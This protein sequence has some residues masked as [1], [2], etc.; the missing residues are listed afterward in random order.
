MSP[1]KR[2]AIFTGLQS[3][4]RYPFS[5]SRRKR[6]RES[7]QVAHKIIIGSRTKSE[8]SRTILLCAHSIGE[9]IFGAERSLLDVAKALTDAGFNIVLAL[10]NGSNVEYLKQLQK[11]AIEI[12]IFPFDQ[13]KASNSKSD[14]SVAAIEAFVSVIDRVKP[15]LIYVNTIVLR[16]PLLA[17]KFRNVPTIVHVREIID[18][19]QDLQK[20][21]GLDADSIIEQLKAS[22]DCLIANSATTAESFVGCNNV[23]VIPNIVDPK[24]FDFPNEIAEGVV[25]FGLIS[26]NLLK[27]GIEDFIELARLCENSI[28]NARFSIIGPQHWDWIQNYISKRK[29]YPSNL[30]FIDYQDS[31]AR[32]IQLVNVVVNFS[33]FKESF[34][35]TVL[36]GMAAGRPTL[37]YDWGALNELVEDE[38]TG[39]LVPYREPNLAVKFV[40]VLCKDLD[41]LERMGEAARLRALYKCRAD[42]FK[43]KIAAACNLAIDT[44]SKNSPINQSGKQPAMLLDKY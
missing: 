2:S 15:D 37:T 21:I 25:R 31:S 35:R 20:Y 1:D 18:Y 33:H 19:D 17:A 30:N 29:A 3:F 6:W 42:I 24:I 23:I 22:C 26:S 28:P 40:Q 43:D 14:K 12:H 44:S 39:F 9:Q 13:W 34:G 36:E 7:K 11:F 5:S 10:Q 32:A 8:S 4:W 16:S 41:N 38:K 27:K